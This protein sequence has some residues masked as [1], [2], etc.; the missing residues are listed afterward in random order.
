MRNNKSPF[1]AQENT[2]WND[3][4]EVMEE[5][6]LSRFTEEINQDLNQ[7]IRDIDTSMGKAWSPDPYSSKGFTYI[8]LDST[9][10][11]KQ[12]KATK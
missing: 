1:L 5:P 8:D 3:V 7:S 9:I 6:Q 11:Q 4:E 10:A 2:I 12:N